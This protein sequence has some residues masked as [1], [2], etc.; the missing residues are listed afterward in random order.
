MDITKIY[1]PP[2]TGKTTTLISTLEK[3][4]LNGVEPTHIAFLTFSRSASQEVKERIL[5]QFDE[6]MTDDDLI[7]FRTIH[8]ACFKQLG[9]ARHNLMGKEKQNDFSKRSGFN[10]V[11]DAGYGELFFSD[12]DYNIC[13][14]ARSLAKSTGKPISE[15]ISQMGE[16]DALNRIN[17]FLRSYHEYKSGE[18]LH[19]FMDM[20]TEYLENPVPLPVRV[21]FLDEAQDLSRLQWNIFREMISEAERVYIAG[22]DDQSIYN[23]I[24]ADPSL[25]NKFPANRVQILDYSYRVPTVIGQK[26]TKIIRRVKDRQDKE[27]KWQVNGTLKKYTGKL[28]K[29]PVREDK[30]TLILCRHR[31]QVL[32][33]SKLFMHIPHMVDRYSIINSRFSRVF[34]I[35]MRLLD[36][37]S[38][39]VKEAARISRYFKVKWSAQNGK[40]QYSL[41]DMKSIPEQPLWLS[42]IGADKQVAKHLWN[43]WRKNYTFNQPPN[44]RIMTMHASK[45]QEA[46]DVFIMT[47]CNMRVAEK[48]RQDHETRLMY[49]ALTRAK[50]TCTLVAPQTNNYLKG[51]FI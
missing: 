47:D 5:K 36:G 12:A 1:G 51:F 20:L 35:H 24:G 38:V 6:R 4:L 44:L 23:F 43:Y 41:K 26:A 49:V 13:L 29:L 34:E 16:H 8:S 31:A 39:S 25:F 7:W 15:I 9:L 27:V 11:K 37:K 28:E 22:D 33:L 42:A 14:Q 45:G 50:Q 21:V 46:D 32:E 30:Q 40:D 48:W 19:D 10:I 17:S 3:E 2:G 18:K